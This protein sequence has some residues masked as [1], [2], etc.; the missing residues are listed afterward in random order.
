[1]DDEYG[2]VIAHKEGQATE[3]VLP[4]RHPDMAAAQHGADRWTRRHGHSALD[5]DKCGF[6]AYADRI[7]RPAPRIYL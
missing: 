1:M 4:E 7:T 3:R 5:T 2:V 6:Y